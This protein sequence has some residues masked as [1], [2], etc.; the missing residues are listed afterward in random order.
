MWEKIVAFFMSIIAFFA[1]L[2]GIGGDNNGD[3]YVKSNLAY[4]SH[5]R[6]VMDLYL[7]QENDGEVG[8]ILFIHGGGWVSG[9]KSVYKDAIRISCED[10]GYAAAAINYRYISETV[11]LNDI[12]DDIELALKKI[13]EEGIAKG[14]NIN[15]VLLT[16]SSAGAHLSMLYAY[17]R[18]DTA[19][20]TPAAVVSNCGPTDL[21]DENFFY[22]GDLNV[23]NGMGDEEF[24]SA[25]FSYAC[26]QKFTYAQRAEAKNALLKVSPIYYIDENTVPTVINHGQKD[27]LVPFSNALSIVEKF[28]EYGVAHDFNIYPNSGHDLA[29]DKENA[30]IANDLL[31][32]YIKTYLGAE[33]TAKW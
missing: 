22:N 6:Q 3:G 19:P 15:K 8:L 17:S 1:S 2:L 23:S 25:L 31:Y 30:Q 11:N 33:A 32:K 24:I 13:K 20:I 9:D 21:S 27:I 26:A 18:K 16:G 28:K 12:A 29:S 14:I 10:L 5:E 4:G 7:P